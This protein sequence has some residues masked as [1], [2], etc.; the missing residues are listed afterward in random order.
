MSITKYGTVEAIVLVGVTT[1][2]E[3]FTVLI[4]EG[5]IELVELDVVEL[6]VDKDDEDVEEL[7]D[8]ELLLVVE[9]GVDEEL[10]VVVDEDEVVVVLVVDL[11]SETAAYAPAAM[12]ITRITTITTA[13]ILLM[14]R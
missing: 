5:V 2:T 14:A 13:T 9:T 6:D 3:Y 8:V 4:T 12:T 1:Q 11:V 7:V 10:L